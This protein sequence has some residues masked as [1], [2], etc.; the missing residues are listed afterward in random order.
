MTKLKGSPLLDIPS[1]L[2]AFGQHYG[3]CPQTDTRPDTQVDTQLPSRLVSYMYHLGQ[4]Y[5]HIRQI[6]EYIFF[7]FNSL[8]KWLTSA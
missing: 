5:Q 8:L 3:P 4:V 2:S 1:W 7:F 6:A